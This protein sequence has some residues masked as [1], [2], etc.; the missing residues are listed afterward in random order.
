[1][2]FDYSEVIVCWLLGVEHVVVL[3][4]GYMVMFEYFDVVNLYFG[5]LLE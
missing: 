3:D 2:F 5:E 1:M 4:V